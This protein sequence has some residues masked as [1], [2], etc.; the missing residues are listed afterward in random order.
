[1]G[2]DHHREDA[3]PK[4]CVAIPDNFRFDNFGLKSEDIFGHAHGGNG[5]AYRILDPREAPAPVPFGMGAFI[6]P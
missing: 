3:D 1:M 5:V 2:F 6:F 4:R